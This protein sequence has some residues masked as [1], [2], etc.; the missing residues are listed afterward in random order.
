MIPGIP[1]HEFDLE[2][3]D[4]EQCA[5]WMLRIVDESPDKLAILT[6]P[7]H[8]DEDDLDQLEEMFRN[9]YD[10]AKAERPDLSV[11]I[12]YAVDLHN[13]QE[14]DRVVVAV[15]EHKWVAGQCV[16]GCP[17]TRKGD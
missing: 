13:G 4:P 14:R 6:I 17:D 3:Y 16:N 1:S 9:A 12:L 10:I 7:P 8:R 2:D 15:H 11:K 5:A